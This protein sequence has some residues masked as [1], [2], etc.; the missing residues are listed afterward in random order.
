MYELCRRLPEASSRTQD[1]KA[2]SSGR[3]K[4]ANACIDAACLLAETVLNLVKREI[5]DRR[6]PMIV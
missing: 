4:L 2:G 6:S 1:G 5:L 3:S